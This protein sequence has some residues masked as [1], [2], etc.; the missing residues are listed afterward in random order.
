VDG[1]F[2]SVVKKRSLPKDRIGPVVI[3]TT[4]DVESLQ[5]FST[6]CDVGTIFADYCD[7]VVRSPG[8]ML[9]SFHGFLQK[10]YA[11]ARPTG[12][13]TL[14]R[15]ENYRKELLDLLEANYMAGDESANNGQAD[16]LSETKDQ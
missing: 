14:T 12:S 9:G 11:N 6:A 13:F 4:R 16:T 8:D 15:L 5:V 1:L 3:L 7:H 10:K 2:Q